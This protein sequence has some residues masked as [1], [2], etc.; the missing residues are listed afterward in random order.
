MKLKIGEYEAQSEN[1][2]ADM[3]KKFKDHARKMVT[4]KQKR[5]DEVAKIK[6]E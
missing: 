3:L 1:Y 5:L 4:K 2:Y 6:K